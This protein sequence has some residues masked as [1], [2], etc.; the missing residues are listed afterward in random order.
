MALP[1]FLSR[2]LP[3][4]FRSTR[5]RVHVLRFHGAIGLQTPLRPGLTAR[6]MEQALQRAFA[7]KGLAAVA[8]VVNSPGGSAVQ[9][10]LIYGRIRQL[11][12]KNQVPVIA[13]CED[14]AASGGYW[15]ACAGDEIYADASS[16]V[17]SIGVISAGFGFVEALAK[18]GIERRVHTVGES[19]S[20][21]D[22]FQ[23]EKPEDVARLKALQLDVYDEFKRLVQERR[24]AKLR[25]DPAEL[26]SGAFWSGRKALELGLLDGLGH[27]HEVLRRRFGENVVVKV[28]EKPQGFSLKRLGFGVSEAAVQEIAATLEERSLWARFGL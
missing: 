18:L 9:S 7:R 1:G 27:L 19:K 13:F 3:V 20:L 24:G 25:G 17:G 4:R 8:L 16:I 5:P 10:A 2:L 15:I 11:A 21:L 23:P 26:F 14:V 22:P 6:G 12:A 28:I